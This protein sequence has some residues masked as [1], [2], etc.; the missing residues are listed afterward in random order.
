MRQQKPC[1]EE[2]TGHSGIRFTNPTTHEV[3][4]RIMNHETISV[5]LLPKNPGD[6]Q[7]HP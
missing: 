6:A 7:K 2:N 5:M 4:S 1:F 3:Y